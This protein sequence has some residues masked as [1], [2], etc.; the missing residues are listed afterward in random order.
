M[1]YDN[2][3]SFHLRLDFIP[4]PLPSASADGLYL[5][6]RFAMWAEE[7][8]WAPSLS[9]TVPNLVPS[10]ASGIRGDPK[11]SEPIHCQVRVRRP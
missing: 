6:R 4:S 9:A 7:S 2:K 1:I 5:N 10:S 8:A 3:P 11:A